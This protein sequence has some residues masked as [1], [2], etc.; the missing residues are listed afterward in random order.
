MLRWITRH[1]TL[2]AFAVVNLA[3][4]APAGAAYDDDVCVEPD[5]GSAPCCTRCIIL[6]ECTLI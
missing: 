6:C 4:A 3:I 2:V 5:G 1:W